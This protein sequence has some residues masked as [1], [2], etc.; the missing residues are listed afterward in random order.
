ML[1]F[2]VRLLSSYCLSLIS[3]KYIPIY[4]ILVFL[5]SKYLSSVQEF[6]KEILLVKDCSR[7][8]FSWFLCKGR[9]RSE[10]LAFKLFKIWTFFISYCSRFD[11]SSICCFIHSLWKKRVLLCERCMYYAKTMWK[12]EGRALEK[13]R[14]KEIS[15]KRKRIVRTRRSEIEGNILCC[16][17]NSY[18][19]SSVMKNSSCFWRIPINN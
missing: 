19:S 12:K 18:R 17:N 5:V 9:S 7:F 16:F 15:V 8:E 10:F 3:L 14:N 1:S 13:E 2:H 6:K 11:I 4:I